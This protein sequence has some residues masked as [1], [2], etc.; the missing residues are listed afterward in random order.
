MSAFALLART[1][2]SM[3]IL[4]HL[5]GF[6]TSYRV[7]DGPRA[8]LR[9]NELTLLSV[10]TWQVGLSTHDEERTDNERDIG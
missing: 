3:S 8:G 7:V 9:D 1:G 10:Q 5:V 2:L 6:G 4:C